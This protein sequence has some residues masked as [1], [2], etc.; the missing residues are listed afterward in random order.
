MSQATTTAPGHP[1]RGN[2]QYTPLISGGADSGGSEGTSRVLNDLKRAEQDFE[3][4]PTTDRMIERVA[5]CMATDT[6]SIMDIGAGDGRVLQQLAERCDHEP[7][8]YAIEKS[9][10]LIQAQPDHI[11]PVGTEFYEQNLAC[12]PVDVIFCNPP[13]SD[14]ETWTAT[15]IE[16]GHAK[17]AFMVI[18]QRWIDSAR[19]KQAIE[20]RG[21]TVRV[22]HS[23]DFH[24]AER[25]AR[26]VVDILDVRYPLKRGYSRHDEAVD[27]FD[28]WFDQNVSTFDKPLE[29]VE[30]LTGEDLAK[31]YGEASIPDMVA[32]YDAEYQIMQ[33]NYRA[34]FGLD[35]ALLRELGVEKDA[36]RSGIKKKMVG[37]KNK[38][39][40]LLFDRLD[41]LTRRFATRT[42]EQFIDT[43][44]RRSSIEFTVSNARAVVIWAIKNA[45]RYYDQ[46]VVD[47]F[48]DL[49]TFDGVEN[50]KSNPK[51]WERDGWRY[52]AQDH[53]HYTLDYR[54][55]VG[56]YHAIATES[57]RSCEYPG[58]LYKGCHEKIADI[59]AVMGNFGYA[60]CS[61]ASRSRTWSPGR[62]QDFELSDGRVLFQVK[63]HKNGNL[64]L[65]FL[66]EAIKQLNV[67]AGRLLGWL[68][69]PQDA[70][71]EI[72][73][74]EAEAVK[75]FGSSLRIAPS[76]VKLLTA[77]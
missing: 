18:T 15:V 29:D 19:I 31:T 21:A 67:E 60:V 37:L 13:Y 39:W 41:A 75:W 17:R 30:E 40:Q 48:R 66:P 10:V 74:T 54:I 11:I 14:F 73:C 45:N 35:Y 2:S 62:W 6:S 4:Y 71:D 16:S 28:L 1:A 24:D 38:Y 55:I 20:R 12:L 49:S 51:T 23:D 56:G 42:R 70:Q 63:A 9:D 47:L 27:P 46:Q 22:I 58:G 43:L 34:I 76:G 25:R 33:D 50:Y 3:W 26:A 8:L 57:W 32:S 77:I 5:A 59:L 52:R 65:R 68:R 69:G 36:V 53:S 44:T 72:G 64:H 7:E 61:P